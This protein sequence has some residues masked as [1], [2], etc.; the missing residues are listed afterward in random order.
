MLGAI[1]F[2]HFMETFRSDAESRG[3]GLVICA[4][5]FFGSAWR[6]SVGVDLL[7]GG[8]HLVF[9]HAQVRRDVRERRPLTMHASLTLRPAI[10]HAAT[11]RATR[12]RRA[13]AAARPMLVHRGADPVHRNMQRLGENLQIRLVLLRV[14]RLSLRP[15]RELLAR[16]NPLLRSNAEFLRHLLRHLPSTWS[17][18]PS[19]GRLPLWTLSLQ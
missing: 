15:P 13:V 7:E 6:R 12:L 17:R 3:K 4:T 5:L 1:L 2:H 11:L 18:L 16:S 14:R 10:L 19:A 8:T 9:A